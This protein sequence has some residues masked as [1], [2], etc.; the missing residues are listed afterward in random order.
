MPEFQFEGVGDFF[1]MGGYGLYV[2]VSYGFFLVV[3]GFN[4]WL[5]L[6]QRANTMRLL[7]ARQLRQQP[8][9]SGGRVVAEVQQAAQQQQAL[10][11]QGIDER[12]LS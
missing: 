7:Q 10:P 4:L 8:D 3:M 11:S 5:P 12:N 2:W 1:A 9:G 6:R